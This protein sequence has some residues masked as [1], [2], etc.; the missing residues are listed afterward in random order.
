M[1]LN[2]EDLMATPVVDLPFV[3]EPAAGSEAGN[4]AGA[5]GGA[6]LTDSDEVL[7]ILRSAL[8]APGVP[9]TRPWRSPRRRTS[10]SRVS[11]TARR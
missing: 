3:I 10:G 9:P 4:G 11:E 8:G 1:A 2:Y 5:G 6:E 7:A